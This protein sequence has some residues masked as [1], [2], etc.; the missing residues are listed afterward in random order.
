MRGH[1]FFKQIPNFADLQTCAFSVAPG[2]KAYLSE[3]S[4]EESAT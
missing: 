2:F 3:S 1:M 4:R